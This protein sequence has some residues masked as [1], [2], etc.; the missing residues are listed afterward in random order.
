MAKRPSDRQLRR[1]ALAL[2]A[3]FFVLFSLRVVVPMILQ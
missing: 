1:I 2:A 3:V